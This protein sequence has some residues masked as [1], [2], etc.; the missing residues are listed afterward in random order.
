MVIVVI[1]VIILKLD[2]SVQRRVLCLIVL[3]QENLGPNFYLK[4]TLSQAMARFLV[5]LALLLPGD[6][7]WLSWFRIPL[8]P[9][10]G[11]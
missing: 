2:I 5:V 8:T 7:H 4:R 9:A 10:G 1:M 6:A 11:K 3:A